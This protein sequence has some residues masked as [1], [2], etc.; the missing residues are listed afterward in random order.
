MYTR[1]NLLYTEQ[2]KKTLFGSFWKNIKLQYYVL[3][4]ADVITYIENYTNIR[5]SAY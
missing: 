4:T 3:S 1:S 2:K 5:V